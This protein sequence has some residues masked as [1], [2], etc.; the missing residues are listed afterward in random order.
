MKTITKS[1]RLMA[2]LFAFLAT[3]TMYSQLCTASFNYTL[4]AN[5]SV[6]F[7]STS[8][9]TN[10]VTTQYFW[11]FGNGNT[12][13]TVGSPMASQ[14]YTANG[15]YTVNLFFLTAPSCSAATTQT[16]LIT[17]ATGCALN[18]NF[19]ISNTGNG[20]YHFNNT[21]TGTNASTHYYWTFGDG[22]LSTLA[23]P[24]H[25]YATGGN[26]LV[27]LT[28]S[29]SVSCI[30]THTMMLNACVKSFSYSTG[31]NGQLF[32]TNTTAGTTSLSTLSWTITNG[33]FTHGSGLAGSNY[34]LSVP[35]NGVYTVGMYIS[36]PCLGVVFN[37]VNITNVS[38]NLNASFNS[39][40][41]AG[42]LVNF[43]ST[44]TGTT[45]GTSYFWNFG[46]GQVGTGNS[47]SHTYTANGNYVV[48]LYA[49]NNSIPS[50]ADSV[51][52]VITVTNATNNPCNVNANF[53][54][55]VG[56]NGLVNFNNTST[57]TSSITTYS[58][59]FGNGQVGSSA[60]PSITYTANG[61]Y[62]VT[63]FVNNGPACGDSVSYLVNVNNIGN[64]C[65]LSASFSYTVGA[66]GLV[67]F[68][69]TSLG[70]NSL[71]TYFWSFGNGS[72]GTGA[73]TSHTF[74][75]SGVYVVVLTAMNGSSLCVN[76]STQSI[77]V[78]G[79]PCIANANFTLSPTNVP[80]YWTATPA[81]PWNVVASSWSWGDGSSDTLLYTSHTYSAAGLYTICL[82]VT[83][84]CGSSTTS[85][86]TYS[87][88]KMNT[89]A[90][91]IHINV[92]APSSEPVGIDNAADEQLEFTLFPN[93]N[94]GSF[95]INL[96]ESKQ[97]KLQ[98]NITNFLGQVVYAETSI[99]A[100]ENNSYKI[101][102]GNLSSGIY[103]MT[104]DVDG[105]TYSK[106]IIVQKQ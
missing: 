27:T 10:S 88:Y 50:C 53:T 16:I 103:L 93:P 56:A 96:G 87:V 105:K 8:L 31:P 66:N 67:N 55:A 62:F 71:T 12:F 91:M 43:N 99:S 38:C 15:T 98:V 3:R 28:D 79:I 97:E 52:A 24:N 59:L 68:S 2:I 75:S 1:I 40:V 26:Y 44:S 9:G 25:T 57:G 46:N 106:K 76:S 45:A 84:S 17:N 58:W 77:N 92:V 11:T 7:M 21:S 95:E 94:N 104:M 54:Y 37:T 60:N 23:S 34:S 29:N 47:A 30:D 65:G 32:L 64:P 5:G 51:A 41:G 69:S 83:V 6:T 90:A 39:V 61:S 72:S 33:T 13:T 49:N 86:S 20:S 36:S 100:N 22:A 102:T 18:A 63:L 85:C 81:N 35:A 19:S 14:T 78:T 42:G 74:G 80:Q 73:N 4:G 101:E 82:T 48:T 89:Q 70:T